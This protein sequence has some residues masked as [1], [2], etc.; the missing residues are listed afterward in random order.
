MIVHMT[1][2]FLIIMDP[3]GNV[4]LFVSILK[5][6]DPVTQRKI[7]L[8]ELLVALAAMIFFIFFGE[9]F[10]K[11]LNIDNHTIEITGGI[12]LFMIA[13]GMIFAKS[14]HINGKKNTKEPLIV[15][16]AIPAVAGPA[17]LAT[18][19]LYGGS[20]VSK[21]LVLLAIFIAWLISVPILLLAP[22]I[23]SVLG[24]NGAVAVERLFGYLIVLISV[25]MISHGIV[26]SFTL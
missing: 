18:I 9:V 4:P 24:N 1:F 23:K 22:Y 25:D 13:I 26:A 21:L 17:I 16:L 5:H 8:R 15:P 19:V 7:I 11:L 10:F 3:L 2:L 20:G 12:I 14:S 6:F